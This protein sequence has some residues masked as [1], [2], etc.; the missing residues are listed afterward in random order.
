MND[1]LDRNKLPNLNQDQIN[2]LNRIKTCKWIETVIRSFPNKNNNNNNK[3][4]NKTKNKTNKTQGQIVL[5]QTF[6]RFSKNRSF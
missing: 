3:T 6:T 5:A 2:N 4:P 1:F